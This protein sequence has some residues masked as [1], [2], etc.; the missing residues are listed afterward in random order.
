MIPTGAR[1][2]LRAL[3]AGLKPANPLPLGAC[4]ETLLQNRAD[5]AGLRQN[6]ENDVAAWAISREG[7]SL[8][9]CCETFLI[10]TWMHDTTTAVYAHFGELSILSHAGA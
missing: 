4:A 2:L 1:R 8:F 6:E 10:T 7:L 3:T 5:I 9:K